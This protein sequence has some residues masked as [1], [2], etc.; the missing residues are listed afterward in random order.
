MAEYQGRGHGF[1]HMGIIGAGNM[2]TSMTLGAS[3]CF[4]TAFVHVADTLQG[5]RKQDLTSRCGVRSIIWH[6]EALLY[7]SSNGAC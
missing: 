7:V 5:S 4:R 1:G 3:D 2:G 6:F